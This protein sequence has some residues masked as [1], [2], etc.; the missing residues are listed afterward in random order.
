MPCAVEHE[1]EGRRTVVKALVFSDLH[2]GHAGD[3]DPAEHWWVRDAIRSHSPN[4]VV[5]AGDVG[6]FW[7]IGL[8]RR[9]DLICAVRE[10]MAWAPVSVYV[11]GN[12]D[13]FVSTLDTS[14]WGCQVVEEFVLEAGPRRWFVAHGDEADFLIWGRGLGLTKDHVEQLYVWVCDHPE[15]A[16]GWDAGEVG[17][18][19]AIVLRAAV[20]MGLLGGWRPDVLDL[21]MCVATSP[22]DFQPS[23]RDVRRRIARFCR[24][25]ERNLIFGHYHH[26]R[27]EVWREFLGGQREA[28]DC[29][30]YTQ[31]SYVVATEEGLRLVRSV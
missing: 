9:G 13:H 25:R 2:I 29:G 6:D 22:W 23:V 4:V 1:T 17:G 18:T 31:R 3:I 27:H 26:P 15:V 21:L 11:L 16:A 19:V 14:A 10:V 28:A 24:P 5:Y 8:D 12:H 20:E 7:R 30:S